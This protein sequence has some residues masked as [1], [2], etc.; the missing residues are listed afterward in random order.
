VAQA[1]GKSPAA[2]EMFFGDMLEPKVDWTEHLKALISR[3][4]GSGG[5][6]FRKPDRR[7][8]VRDIIA[9]GRTGFGAGLVVIG[10]DSS[11]S[12]YSDPRLIDRWMGELTGIMEDIPTACST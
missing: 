5:Y 2:F 11:G 1:Q 7:L 12:I 10:M 8:I 9:P 4:V 3:K 6:D